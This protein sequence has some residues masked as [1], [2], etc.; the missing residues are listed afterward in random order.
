MDE[1]EGFII[2]ILFG[3]VFGFGVGMVVDMSPPEC[4][5]SSKLYHR[6]ILQ[7][8]TNNWGNLDECNLIK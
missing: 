4:P 6:C 7:K 3:C 5:D 1:I 8:T 2:G